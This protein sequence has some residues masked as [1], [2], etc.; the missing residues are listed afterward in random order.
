M[1]T[2]HLVAARGCSGVAAGE[3]QIAA[4]TYRE[5]ANLAAAIGHIGA[6]L[7]AEAA[8]DG[9]DA[10]ERIADIAFVLH[11]RDVEASLCDALDAA[12]RDVGAASAIFQFGAERARQAIAQLKE[13]AR[14]LDGMIARSEAL[15][16]PEAAAS[17]HNEAAEAD[18]SIAKLP[19]LY[20]A[21][22]V[23]EKPGRAGEHLFHADGE[24]I[25]Q[26]ERST[27]SEAQSQAQLPEPA[28]GPEDD[29]GELF[30]PVATRTLAPR[31][32]TRDHAIGAA[33][34]ENAGGV[35]PTAIP[36]DL[37]AIP[38]NP[39]EI[40]TDMAPRRVMPQAPLPGRSL[41]A[42]SG[43]IDPLVPLG[44]LGEEE[45]IALFS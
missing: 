18:V 25:D 30:E 31:G 39:T 10:I 36:T 45:M 13:I 29:P 22:S 42:Q 16:R 26:G 43:P 33:E 28:P 7:N 6:L 34:A 8:Q 19:S 1:S 20:A 12:V 27:P 15:L 35:S 38:T 5:L 4:V 14:R 37:T 44:A 23:R 3:P 32:P 2:N 9:S 21:E 41:S 40:P 17:A 24:R 11:E